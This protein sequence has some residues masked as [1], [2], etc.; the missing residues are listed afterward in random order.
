MAGYHL[1]WAQTPR[2]TTTAEIQHALLHFQH[3]QQILWPRDNDIFV[4]T[5]VLYS[6]STGL[7]SLPFDFVSIRFSQHLPWLV[8]PRIRDQRHIHSFALYYWVCVVRA[9][10]PHEPMLYG[11]KGSQVFGMF[12]QGV[13]GRTRGRHE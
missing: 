7:T 9:N 11:F 1:G 12:I 4:T 8:A 10:W 3:Y 2:D 13:F 6:S 5:F